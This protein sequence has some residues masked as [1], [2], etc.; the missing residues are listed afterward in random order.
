VFA[1]LQTRLPGGADSQGN[2]L[3]LVL[4][5]PILRKVT[6]SSVTVWLALSQPADVTLTVY[7]GDEQIS[8]VLASGDRKTVSVGKNIHI[9]CVTT[10]PAA[11]QPNLAGGTVYSYDLSFNTATGVVPLLKAVGASGK[12]AYAYGA[13][14]RPSFALPPDALESVR[15]IQGSCRKPNA[16]GPDALAMLDDLIAASVDSA[17]GRPHQLLLTGD[18]IYAD[19]VSDILLLMLTDAASVLIGAPEPLPGPGGSSQFLADAAPPTTRTDMIKHQAMLTTDESRSHLMSFGEF[20]AMYLFVWS[21]VLWPKT[22]PAWPDLMALPPIKAKSDWSTALTSLMADILLKTIRVDVFRQT[23][24]TVRRALANVPTAMILDDHEIT[25][26]Y[27]M[28]PAFCNGV[29]GSDLGMRIIQNGLA[30]YAV[31]QHWGNAPE[32][33]ERNAALGS[34]DPAGVWLLKQFDTIT[35]SQFCDDPTLKATLGLHAP[36][37]LQNGTLSDGF[38][39]RTSTFAVFHDVG[40]RA[41][42]PNGWLDSKSLLYHYTLE[43]NAYQVIVTDSR[44]WRAFPRGGTFS[45]PDLIAQAQVSFQIGQTPKLNNRQLLVVVTTNM[46]PTPPIRQGARDLPTLVKLPGGPKAKLWYEDFYDS[47]EIERIDCARVLA[48][49][50]RKFD[51][52]NQNVHAGGVVLLSGDV[53]ASMASRIA[54]SATLQQVGDTVGSPSKAEVTLAQLIGSALH[55]QSNDTKVQHKLGYS[56]VPAVIKDVYVPAAN[57]TVGVNVPEALKQPIQL[58]EEF[59]G[60]NPVTTPAMTKLGVIGVANTL[61]DEVG[62]FVDIP[63]SSAGT[64]DLVFK[65]DRCTVT[66]RDE[67]RPGTAHSKVLNISTTPHYQIRL[68]YLKVTDSGGY[69]KEPPVASNSGDPLTDMSDGVHAYEL[70][71]RAQRGGSEIVGLNN[72]GEITFIRHLGSFVSPLLM[73]RYMVHWHES[74]RLQFVFYDVSLD[75]GDQSFKQLPYP[76]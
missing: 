23:V 6:Q 34:S 3:P 74:G 33:F 38:Q 68:D 44:T 67:V 30:A 56:Y 60:W 16:E 54:Y 19:E 76:T 39:G 69:S 15:L 18:Q 59:V 45:P 46:P 66:L 48:E 27:N 47:W 37:Q 4:A 5:G 55:N 40:T 28:L 51:L 32:Q 52:N 65:P 20:V 49:I 42:T 22:L 21:D 17:L 13:R 26:D 73:V 72:I 63:V 10:T 41:Q 1:S 11:G 71:V 53:H 7:A 36:T 62:S 43:A 64:R 8:P 24:T 50:S 14:Q 75:V 57:I 35:Y 31:C 9:V 61:I 12:D 25:D 58:T 70:Y 29:Y 2:P